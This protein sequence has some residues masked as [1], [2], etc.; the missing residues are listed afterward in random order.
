[1][2]GVSQSVNNDNNNN[3]SNNWNNL[4]PNVKLITLMQQEN[5]D[6]NDNNND[7]SNSISKNMTIKQS[8][9]KCKHVNVSSVISDNIESNN[10]HVM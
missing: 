4:P 1:M 9:L 10:N 5:N 3:N 8:D 6:H 7:N 2:G